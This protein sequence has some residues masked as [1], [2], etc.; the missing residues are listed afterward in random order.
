MQK[1]FTTNL[2]NR[3]LGPFLQRVLRTRAALR[4]F[5][6]SIAREGER[7]EQAS[8]S[9]VNC[10]N[11]SRQTGAINAISQSKSVLLLPP[12][13]GI[14]EVERAGFLQALIKLPRGYNCM[15]PSFPHSH[16]E[17]NAE[18]GEHEIYG[19]ILSL[20]SYSAEI[21]RGQMTGNHSDSSPLFPR[22]SLGF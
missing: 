3:A 17:N 4:S 14:K 22:I 16:L 2:L 1:E 13:L 15:S 9:V 20:L 18:S 21:R 10:N 5:S 12:S 11:R 19:P 8:D 6:L 7:G